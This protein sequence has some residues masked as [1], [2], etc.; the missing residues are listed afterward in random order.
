ML[1]TTKP[2]MDVSHVLM[3]VPG[4][5]VLMCVLAVC[6]ARMNLK[7]QPVC[8]FVGMVSLYVELRNVMIEIPKTLMVV[9]VSVKWRMNTHVV[10]NH[11][12]VKALANLLLQIVAME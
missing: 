9:P 2:M 12:F 10:R 11:P 7:E 1:V 3:D 6:L 8:L 5:T 4:V